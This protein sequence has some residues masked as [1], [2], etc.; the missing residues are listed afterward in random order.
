MPLLSATM[1][2]I[3]FVAVGCTPIWSIKLAPVAASD[4]QRISVS[5]ARPAN[6]RTFRAVD[7][8]KLTYQYYLGDSNVVPDRVAIFTAK[9]NELAPADV[10]SASVELEHFEILR[11][12][13]G[14]ACTGCAL[15]AVSVPAAIGASSNR[16]ASDDYFQCTLVASVNGVSTNK[17]A[18]A[19][20]KIGGFDSPTNSKAVVSALQRCIDDVINAW[21]DSAF[22]QP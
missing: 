5:D 1:S 22:P 3:A 16:E 7:F 14:S 9:V 19:P 2:L 4:S 11:D 18:E 15:A 10:S 13:S 17:V 20:Y 8:H 12:T 21:V 6:E